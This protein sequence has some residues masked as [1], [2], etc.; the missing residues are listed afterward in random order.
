MKRITKTAALLL[1]LLLFTG[2]I[3]VPTRCVSNCVK[4]VLSNIHT[5]APSAPV[6]VQTTPA[7]VQQETD[8]PKEPEVTEEP[9]K[10]PMPQTTMAPLAAN[11]AEDEKFIRLDDEMFRWYVTSEI[12]SLDQYCANPEN[13]GIDESTV[14]V[15]LGDFSEEANDKWAE[16]CMQWRARLNEINRSGLS[17]QYAFAYDTYCRFFDG[18][19]ESKDFFYNY[20]PL[21]EYVGLHMNLPLVFGLYT[22]RDETDVKNYLTLLADVPRYMGQVLAFEQE[23][24]NRGLFMTS[25]M[26]TM[27]LSD[28]KT[29][30]ESG[31]TSYLHDTFRE[32]MEKIDFLTEQQKEKYEAQ[33]DELIRTKWVEGYQ[34]LYDGLKELRPKCRKAVG[35]YEQGGIAYDYYLWKLRFE[36]AGNRTLDDEIKLMESCIGEMYSEF[37]TCATKSYDQLMKDPRLTLGSLEKDEA[38]LKT[39]IPYI[40]PTMPEVYV[41][42]LEIPEEL[43]ESFS[44]A[45][46][47]T[48][49][50]DDYL[51]N[52]ILTNPKDEEDYSISTLAHEGYPGHMYQYVY[53]YALGTIPKFQFAIETNG[54]A[55]A[56]STNSELNIARMNTKFGTDLATA[57]FLNDYLTNLIVMLCSLRVNGQGATKAEIKNYLSYWGL[58][59]NVDKIYDICI[60]LPIYYFKYA[61]GFAELYDMTNRC[62]QSVSKFNSIEYYREYLS[63]GPSYFD[64]LNERMDAWVK[65]Q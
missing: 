55:E 34:L 14:P 39:L 48:P 60:N 58:D 37:I 19:I 41:D 32:A 61:G 56:W 51:N 21:D 13:F 15:T 23:R 20:E 4:D 12:I 3:F 27:I 57:V 7:P 64:L 62:K 10:T 35:A 1:A 22:F 26:L 38:Y 63:W 6:S 52:I 44:P 5:A 18:E 45:A 33:N 36:T 46:Y 9:K 43:Q 53:Q 50:F 11:T 59:A 47:L 49:A 16:D 31:E 42:Y 40:V 25:S 17:E 28:L 54:Y 29:V 65:A 2:C 30:A 24:A 8:A